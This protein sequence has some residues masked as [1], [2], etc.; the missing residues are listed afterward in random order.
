[1]T[2]AWFVIGCSLVTIAASVFLTVISKKSS[3]DSHLS[4]KRTAQGW[5]EMNMPEEAAKCERYAA[6]AL[7]HA[8]PFKPRPED[9]EASE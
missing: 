7:R 9:V 2:A 6:K 5:R 1:M 3:L 4:L 8:W